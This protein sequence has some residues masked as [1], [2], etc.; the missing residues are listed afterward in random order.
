MVSNS[1]Q[2]L[3]NNCS[4]KYANFVLCLHKG[5]GADSLKPYH[6]NY[7]LTLANNNLF[8]QRHLEISSVHLFSKVS[9]SA[10]VWKLFPTK[11]DCNV[12]SHIGMVGPFCG[13]SMIDCYQDHALISST[14]F[15][16]SVSFMHSP[17]LKDFLWL[18]YRVLKSPSKVP[19]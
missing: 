9:G 7:F 19:Q 15:D 1:L 10:Q 2:S 12:L 17:C 5:I 16:N 18:L 8:L 13:F 14:R 11:I 6:E 3:T 4:T